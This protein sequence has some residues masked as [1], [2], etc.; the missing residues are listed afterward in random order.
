MQISFFMQRDSPKKILLLYNFNIVIVHVSNYKTPFTPM[1]NT[2]FPP[3]IK[4][5]FW[6]FSRKFNHSPD[7]Y[8]LFAIYSSN[9]AISS[10][11]M[12]ID[13]MEIW[14]RVRFTTINWSA[15][16]LNVFS[17]GKWYLVCGTQFYGIVFENARKVE[18]KTHTLTHCRRQTQRKN[19]SSEVLSCRS[20]TCVFVSH[21]VA[22]VN[23]ANSVVACKTNAVWAYLHV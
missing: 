23:A 12:P 13:S 11:K 14:I 17:N 3:K 7:L 21:S 6:I 9:V 4:Y 16:W 22:K 18:N 5:V 10:K 19:M 20:Y 8:S 2:I 15:R 1:T